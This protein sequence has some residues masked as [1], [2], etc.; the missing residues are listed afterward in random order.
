MISF[1]AGE[2]R[3][4]V[5]GSS[6]GW[7]GI[8]KFLNGVPGQ[9][10]LATVRWR[11]NLDGRPYVYHPNWPK[12]VGVMAKKVALGSKTCGLI[13]SGRIGRSVLRFF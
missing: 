6:P 3:K 13:I 8:L 11:V 5:L 1:R 12:I 7:G 4:G 2:R 9:C 10:F